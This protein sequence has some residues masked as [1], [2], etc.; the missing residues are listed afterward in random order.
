[1]YCDKKTM[2]KLQANSLIK[3]K[4]RTSSTTCKP[5]RLPRNL[6]GKA[7]RFLYLESKGFISDLPIIKKAIMARK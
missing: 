7:T 2:L 5:K 1:M 3:V 4:R 6:P